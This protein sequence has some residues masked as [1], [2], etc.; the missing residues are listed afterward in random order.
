MYFDTTDFDL[1][2]AGSLLARPDPAWLMDGVIPERGL[3]GLYGKPSSGK[4]FVALDW[5]CHI[6]LGRPWLGHAVQRAPV[7]YIA[8]EGA[9]GMQKRLRAW[10][11]HYGLYNDVPG[12]YFLL[13]PLYVREEGVVEAFLEKLEYEDLNPGLIV[14]DTLSRSF[15]GGEE[16]ASEDMGLFVDSVTKLALGRNLA[17]LVVHH[18]NA[19]ANRERGHTAF[20]GAADAMFRCDASH[21]KQGL[22]DH[23]TLS[24]DKQKDIAELAPIHLMPEVVS[25]HGI[26]SLVLIPA[27]EPVDGPSASL[28]AA[29]ARIPDKASTRL[30]L[31]ASDNG[32][33]FNEWWHA[34]QVPRTTFRRRLRQLIAQHE[35]YQDN[36]RYFIMPSLEDIAELGED[37]H[38]P[39]TVSTPVDTSALASGGNQHPSAPESASHE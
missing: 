10:M 37:T 19:T 17:S 24:N 4:S 25:S 36:G 8:A 31:A 13:E 1:M 11:T 32:L 21:N 28:R 34:S 23:V 2:T 7:I 9:T 39:A 27:P 12:L 29:I 5:A 30:V 18:V 22:L 6:A 33:T 15:G 35:V 26:E 16:N 3:V 38:A 20:R 14:V